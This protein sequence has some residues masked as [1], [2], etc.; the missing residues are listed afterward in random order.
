MVTETTISTALPPMLPEQLVTEIYQGTGFSWAWRPFTW[1]MA[2]L[3]S[4][5]LALLS[6]TKAIVKATN[7]VTFTV[8]FSLFLLLAAVL[9]YI[10]YT[11]VKGRILSQ[12][13]NLQPTPLCEEDPIKNKNTADQQ[14]QQHSGRDPTLS[15]YLDQFLSA[16]KI[17][18]YL[19]KP[20][21]HELT[22]NMRTQKLD[23]GEILLLD[24][25]I[26]FA[27]VVEGSLQIYHHVE[28][29]R[30]TY[31]VPFKPLD[32]RDDSNDPENDSDVDIDFDDDNDTDDLTGDYI[33]LRDG[34]GKFQLLNTVKP[35]NPVSSLVNILN[36]FVLQDPTTTTTGNSPLDSPLSR[37]LN[38]L[39][40]VVPNVVARAATDCTIAIIPPHAFAHLL[41]MFPRSAAHITQMILTKLYH[42]TFQTVHS[43]LG[44]TNEIM[45]IE[46]T[47]NRTINYKIPDYL[48][49]TVLQQNNTNY[50]NHNNGPNSTSNNNNNNKE[51]VR[52]PPK[53]SNSSSLKSFRKEKTRPPPKRDS[54]QGSRHVVLDA[55][56]HLNPG[57]LLSNV[58]L[59]RRDDFNLEAIEG[60]TLGSTVHS[61]TSAS[62]SDTQHLSSIQT[63]SFS[64]VKEE[65]ETS[66]ARMALIEAMFTFLGVTRNNMSL[67]S[68]TNLQ[69]RSSE[70]SLTNSFSSTSSRSRNTETNLRILPSSFA[71]TSRGRQRNDP[72]RSKLSPKRSHHQNQ[73]AKKYKE[74]ISPNL[75]FESAKAEFAQYIKI[76][77][78]KRGDLIIKQNA[79]GKGLFY[80]IC[81]SIDVTSSRESDL[82][83]SKERHI[84]TVEAGGIAGYLS[85]LVGY[86]SF[87]N[88]RAKT[89]VTVGFL[90]NEALERLCDKYFLIYL[91]I[92]ETLTGLLSPRMLK[93][94]HAL[95]WIHL[96]AS[97]TLFSQ[98]DPANGIYVVLNGRL[99][100]LQTETTGEEPQGGHKS[101]PP[102]SQTTSLGE[103]A[104]GESLGEVEVLTA[105]NRFTTTVAV[106]DSE[107]ARIPRTLFELLAMEH[108]S[109]MIR[110]SRLVAKKILG[111]NKQGFSSSKITGEN[112][113]R[114]DFD[115]TIPPTKP[116]SHHHTY[117]SYNQTSANSGTVKY[118]TIT[119]I[120]VTA[121]LPVETFAHK[122]VHAFKQVGRNT[123]GLTQSTTLSHLGRHAFDRLASL[124]Q[125]G[126]FAELE[127]IYDTVVY[128]GDTAVNSTWTKTCIDQGDC[129][130]LLANSSAS[131]EIGEYEKL[132]LKSKTTARTELILLH[133]ERYVEAGLTQQ[134]LRHRSWVDSHHHIQFIVSALAENVTKANGS[135]SAAITLLDKL[136][137]TDLGRKTY[138]I[139]RLLPDSIKNTVENFSLRFMNKSR[140]VYNPV[141]VH[142][143]DFLRLARILSGQAIGLVLGGG[144]A[145][146]ISHLGVLQAIEEQ[147]I[148][149]DIIG[150]TS[151]G[152]FIG[153][154]YAR[155][156]D[157]VSIY[158]RIKKFAGR[159]S[160]LWRMMSDLTWP[161][162]S[163]TTGHEFNRGIWKT[164]GD[165]RIEDFWLQYYCNSTNITESVQEIHSFGYAW[166]YIRASMSLA[167]L[168]P[169][170]EEN[171]SM[172][173]DGGYVDNLP[174]GEM[175]ARGC[176]VIFAIDVGSMDDRTPMDFGDSLNG[177]WIMF[178]RWNPFSSH[179]NIPNMA[180]IQMRLGYV[181]SVNALEK[182]K[183]TKGVIY[184]RPPIDGYTTLDF[185]RF[186]EIYR[187]GVEYGRKFL[188]SLVDEDKMPFI[189]GFQ[190]SLTA[191]V[192]ELL[193]HRR[194]SI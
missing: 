61:S 68:E 13:K 35:G 139:K 109:I 128:I 103:L 43:Y 90:S 33:Y 86:R 96:S 187:V 184:A 48:I 131:T 9:C 42:V 123:I 165:T 41:E 79:N 105:M 102:T 31:G 66:A 119:I 38:Q 161:V 118:R 178:N 183:H 12:Y 191:S 83:E 155:D 20:V 67:D 54:Q 164:F 17:F 14:Q 180:E 63:T 57:D 49:R 166:R 59:S 73:G 110:V 143:S 56:D 136:S 120:P 84:F 167:G 171:G 36:L 185:A 152:S 168:L 145:R 158:G 172:L 47:L 149:I 3:R 111:N 62:T 100:Q 190:D 23:E 181:A 70:T 71:V 182:A 157:V 64:S 151:I 194:N 2:L 5:V 55:R 106:R 1:P 159:I 134:W 115:L 107:L 192:P 132:L 147:G 124:K 11:V 44:L 163:Y 45:S 72:S 122:L 154:L 21:F 112:G 85:S 76:I 98:G 114:Y 16:I 138:N 77:S 177:F 175:K 27:I 58:P 126:Y 80:V 39:P 140:Q 22:K 169:P 65:T 150:G 91:R 46:K 40:T 18:G 88:L 170:L 173:L 19:E 146:G 29:R 34:L 51:Y 60:D 101:E 50:H 15:S 32:P 92:A 176:N 125:S 133:E 117:S 121:G 81:G 95:E 26:G 75:D 188:Q 82:I 179:P 193:L 189:P 186:E 127:Q 10:T 53:L 97:D 160:S 142:K 6:I 69:H 135:N 8:P 89:D 78:Y 7:R 144:G 130:L 87:T 94:D 116:K 174:V 74:E 153:G 93:L 28:E 141:H 113:N 137:Q 162:T 148:P 4:I 37:S 129:I 156:Y 24:N 99:R 30:K 104:Q 25:A 108:P 52:I